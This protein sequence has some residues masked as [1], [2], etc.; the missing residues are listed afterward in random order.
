MVK[1][2]SNKY[3]MR[4]YVIASAMIFVVLVFVVRLFQIQV[5]SDK[6]KTAG[7]NLAFLRRTLY[8]SRGLIYDN[9][10]KLVVYNKAT[11]NIQVITREIEPFDS[12]ELCAIL[13]VPIEQLRTRF[14]EIRDKRKNRG[15]SPYT[16]QLLFTQIST[17]EASLLEEKLY[18]YPGFYVEHRTTRDY[19]TSAAALVLGSVGEVSRKDIDRDSYYVPSDYAGTTGIE[20]YYEKYLRG[21]KGTE[22][23][24]R[25][26]HGRVQGQYEDG[27]Y[28]EQ[29]TS[30]HNLK[31]SIDIALQEYGELLMKN[32][33]GAIVMI[34]PKTGEVRAMVAAPTYAPAM[35]VGKNRG[36]NFQFL[37]SDKAKP[38]F[39]RATLGAYPPG[40]TFKPVQAA[41]F[42]QEGAINSSTMYTCHH[43][44]PLGYRNKP[45]CHGHPSP[46]DLPHALA[47]SCN[48]YFCWGLRE[49]L[50][51]RRR[52]S[53]IQEAFE[54]WKRHAVS[55][56]F[57]Y[58][59]GIDLPS[60]NRGYIPNAKVYD[61]IFNGKWTSGSVI[62]ISI[63]QGE[64]LATP[65]QIANAGAVI[66]NRGYYMTPHLVKEIEGIPLDSLH[67]ERHQS[68]V[69]ARHFDSIIQGM[70]MAVTGGTC[71]KANIPDIAVC[72]KTGT[73]ENP[74]GED[75]SLFLGFAPMEDPQIVI[76]L[77]VENAGFGATYAVP[78]GRLMLEFYL[79]N[80]EVPSELKGVE[81]QMIN[82][83]INYSSW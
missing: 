52:Y 42:L 76:A 29:L 36:K 63:G 79:R 44:Y 5:L 41:A 37:Q 16:P 38:L 47:T 24:L 17:A 14:A 75:H 60:E 77:I 1:E 27:R 11:A 72:G 30:G 15:Y 55:M 61:K 53:S 64:I 78:I 9:Q 6:Y 54:S 8:P 58:K 32:K 21:N 69:E 12:L 57:G 46:L 35:L 66:A 31:M 34:E 2:Y 81:E 39:N 19:N 25:D 3:S 22:V 74:H 59:L 82:A 28:D 68:S 50:D 83:R 56:G 62:S 40:S 80:G 51:N 10:G 4:K 13:N 67:I 49:Y 26:A 43:G 73:A 18:K 71:R 45:A 65:L 48:A 23:L 7:E 20:K 33:R 70:R